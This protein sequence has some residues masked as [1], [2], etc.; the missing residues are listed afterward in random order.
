MMARAA[1]H[2]VPAAV[3]LM[4]R[5]PSSGFSSRPRFTLLFSP[6]SVRRARFYRSAGAL[7]HCL[8]ATAPIQRRRTSAHW[9]TPPV[10]LRGRALR[11]T[12]AVGVSSSGSCARVVGAGGVADPL[13]FAVSNQY[14]FAWPCFNAFWQWTL[15]RLTP[16]TSACRTLLRECFSPTALSTWRRL[17]GFVR[18]ARATRTSARAR[19]M[20]AVFREL[21]STS[22]RR[23][24]MSSYT[25]RP[26]GTSTSRPYAVIYRAEDGCG[27][28]GRTATRHRASPA[29]ASRRARAHRPWPMWWT[30]AAS[31]MPASPSNA[32]NATR[33]RPTSCC[34]SKPNASK[35]G[36]RQSRIRYCAPA[37]RSCRAHPRVQ[38]D[39][40]C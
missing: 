15:P 27:V 2:G 4:S 16:S 25:R 7:A 12:G 39:R 11:H 29:P 24:L 18:F 22:L 10:K 8:A 13:Q 34:S 35:K 20:A 26:S 36:R 5:T 40:G 17:I 1:F 9:R 14:Q 3:S 6:A 23:R 19:S 38:M 28:C 21:P 32:S 33:N 31:G 37:A 30:T